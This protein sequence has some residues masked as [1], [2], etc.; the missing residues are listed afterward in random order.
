[1]A[2]NDPLR[3]SGYLPLTGL[4]LRPQSFLLLYRFPLNGSLPL[5]AVGFCD[6]IEDFSPFFCSS[7]EK[8][9]SAPLTPP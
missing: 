6:T 9:L 8:K 3:L 2:Q 5:F 7:H 4:S 1:M